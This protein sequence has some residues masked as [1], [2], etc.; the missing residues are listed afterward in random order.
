MRFS[1]LGLALVCYSM[2]VIVPCRAEE[3]P[4]EIKS[5]P[6]AKPPT[7]DGVL[8]PGEWKGAAV[9]HFEM[10]MLR[11]RPAGK[12]EPRK[13]TLHVMNSANGLYV[14][15]YHY[16]IPEAIDTMHKVLS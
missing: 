16:A 9:Y 4:R 12:A 8:E 13:C 15:N 3:L 11:V 7:V 2:S 6:C 14:G 5:A 10:P 1:C